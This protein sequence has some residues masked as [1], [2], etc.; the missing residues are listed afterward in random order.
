MTWHIGLPPNFRG[1]FNKPAVIL[2]SHAALVC[3]VTCHVTKSCVTW[4]NH[5]SRENLEDSRCSLPGLC[6]GHIRWT[7]T[8]QLSNYFMACQSE[9]KH[10][11]LFHV[12]LDLINK[13]LLDHISRFLNTNLSTTAGIYWILISRDTFLKSETLKPN[14][15]REGQKD[16][17]NMNKIPLTEP[18]SLIW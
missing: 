1:W 5:V 3:D 17:L 13:S 6:S 10:V 18:N 12:Y 14:E 15:K 4:P 7:E 11:K 8:C 9:R 16:S 2:F